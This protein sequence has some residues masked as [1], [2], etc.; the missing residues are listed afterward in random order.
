MLAE[1]ATTI[2]SRELQ[3]QMVALVR[4]FG[5]HRADQTPCGQPISVTEA[6]TLMELSR[7]EP[8]S[9]S[10]LAARLRL[11]KSTVSRLVGV[12]EGREWITRTRSP[13][14]GR[15]VE[16]RLSDAGRRAAENVAET[17][18][19]KFAR[20]LAAIPEEQRGSVIDALRILVEAIDESQ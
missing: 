5:L 17:R 15:A 16:L 14:D 13:S 2:T 11:E 20:V 10:E 6:Y 9:Q 7:A 8:L 18:Q 4:A 1:L 12:L 19:A 3:E